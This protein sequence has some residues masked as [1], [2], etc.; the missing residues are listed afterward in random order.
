MFE[1]NKKYR[2][3]YA[4]NEEELV[5]TGRV[6]EENEAF[7]KVETIRNETLILRLDKIIKIQE[8]EG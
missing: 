7:I 5:F 2:I 4:G 8:V 6:I 3:Q 1:Q